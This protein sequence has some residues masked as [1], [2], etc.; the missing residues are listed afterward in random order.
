MK[1]AIKIFEHHLLLYIDC[2]NI[3][4]LYEITG[5]CNQGNHFDAPD[6]SSQN[7][8]N[9]KVYTISH[10]KR[11]PKST[12]CYVL[13]VFIFNLP[14]QFVFFIIE[15]ILWFGYISLTFGMFRTIALEK[16][17]YIYIKFYKNRRILTKSTLWN[18]VLLTS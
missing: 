18:I 6:I 7:G 11:V 13:I 8:N 3:I 4:I 1:Y 17:Q 16:T 2:I 15:N 5:I 9:K 10:V 14:I 12:R